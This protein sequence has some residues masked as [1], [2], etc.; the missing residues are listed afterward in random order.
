ML[1]LSDFETTSKSFFT[2]AVEVYSSAL[3]HCRR[4]KFRIQLHLTL[5]N[6]NIVMLKEQ[7]QVL[8]LV[9]DV[10]HTSYYRPTCTAQSRKL[11]DYV[12]HLYT[13]PTHISIIFEY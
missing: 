12:G 7:E 5:I 3:N 2:F 8:F 13:Y 10:A 1:R 9:G 11:I 4:I 6:K